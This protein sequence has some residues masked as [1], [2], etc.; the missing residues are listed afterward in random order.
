[1]YDACYSCSYPTS[2][3]CIITCVLSLSVRLAYLRISL[4]NQQQLMIASTLLMKRHKPVYAS[5]YAYSVS[6]HTNMCNEQGE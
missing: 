2:M 1:M 4:V 5:V 6:M 3:L